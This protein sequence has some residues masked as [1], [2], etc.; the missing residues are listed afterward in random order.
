L[1]GGEGNHRQQILKIS[2]A[3]PHCRR[4]QRSETANPTPSEVI[5]MTFV[6][7]LYEAVNLGTKIKW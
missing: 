1:T 4:T 6:E 5:P 2:G 7:M 3:E